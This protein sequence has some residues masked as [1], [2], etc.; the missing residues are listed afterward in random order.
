MDVLF[1]PAA[2][3][4]GMVGLLNPCGFALFP[5]YLSYFLGSDDGSENDSWL[6]SLNRAQIVGLSLSAG[7]V[8]VFA[9]IGVIFAG[10]S[11][12][13]AGALPYVTLVIGLGLAGL[14]VAM[15]FGFQPTVKLPKMDAG[16]ESRNVFSMFLFG[17]SY[18]LASL[19]CTLPIFLLAVG[20]ASSGVGFGQRFG[21]LLS[22]GVGMGLLATV[23]TLLMAFGKKGLV[24]SFRRI[25]PT[26]NRYS[27]VVVVI[28]G[29]Y[30]VYYGYWSTDPTGIAM[31]PVGPVEDAQ[32]WV[33][34]LIRPRAGVL[35]IGFVVI[36]A[37]IAAGGLAEYFTTKNS[38]QGGGP[39][40][41]KD[42]NQTIS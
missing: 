28:V 5:A 6:R 38:G 24:S 30:L 7:F 20:S 27:G 41:S 23:L 21:S 34:N 16:G 15:I 8:A 9:V 39:V 18:A 35:A 25:L 19:T 33:E 26:I 3:A 37:I 4:F 36:N 12:S 14:G 13:I 31:G 10:L 1:D 2:I 40:A 32:R 17:V 42:A 29:L 22:Y 11:D